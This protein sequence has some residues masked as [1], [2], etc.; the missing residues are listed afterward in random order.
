[1]G[2]WALQEGQRFSLAGITQATAQATAVTNGAA[3]VKGAWAPL[4][5]SLPHDVDAIFA[6]F[7]LKSSTSDYAVDLG[8]GAASAEQV[9][10]PNLYHGGGINQITKGYF[11]PIRARAGE[12]LAVR[13]QGANAATLRAGL[14][15]IQAG[16][17]GMP[18][19]GRCVDLGISTSGA[20]TGT[21]LF[22]AETTPGTPGSANAYR[23]WVQASA[24]APFDIQW[25]V[26]APGDRS[27]TTRTAGQGWAF[28]VGIGAAGSEQ[29]EIPDLGF[30]STSSSLMPPLY[31]LPV[32][33]R[34]GERIAVRGQ[35][36]ATTNADVDIWMWGFG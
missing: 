14:Q 29:V 32:T 30:Y 7:N 22:G 12:R 11:L 18:S 19:F 31:S 27:L 9:L 26:I 8:V 20:T 2:D 13:S 36:T 34:A 17:L 6:S 15:V 25:L 10:V 1:M 28:D 16:M 33:I 35:A 5:A 24:A 4:I 3:N 21:R 23:A